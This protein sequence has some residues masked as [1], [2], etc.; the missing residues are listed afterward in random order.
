MADFKFES[1]PTQEELADPSLQQQIRRLYQHKLYNRWLAVIYLWIIVVPLSLWS[2][3]DEI[4][5]WLDYFTW[6]AVRYSFIYN[7]LAAVGLIACSTLTL[8][9]LL[10]QSRNILFGISPHYHRRLEKQVLKIRQQ[11]KTHPLWSCIHKPTN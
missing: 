9:T 10:W 7:P 1:N 11:G 8:T 5:L 3:R 2:L 6:T 4:P